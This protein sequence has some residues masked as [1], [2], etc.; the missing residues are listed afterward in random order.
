[1]PLLLADVNTC[2]VDGAFLKVDEEGIFVSLTMFFFYFL[3]LTF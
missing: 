1:M 2:L 3:V